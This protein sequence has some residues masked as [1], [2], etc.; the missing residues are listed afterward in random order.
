MS[1]NPLKPDPKIDQT[2]FFFIDK[3]TKSEENN[4]KIGQLLARINFLL[5]KVVYISHARRRTPN[6]RGQNAARV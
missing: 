1:E 6:M 3:K 5:S 4:K 2:L